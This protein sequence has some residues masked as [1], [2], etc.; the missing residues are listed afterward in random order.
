MR[1]GIFET[2]H[3]EV[4]H[5]LIRLFQSPSNQLT[6]FSYVSSWQQLQMMPGIDQHPINWVVKKENQSKAAFIFH[7]YQE[8]KKEKIQLLYLDTVTDNFIF[9]AWLVKALPGVRILLT[10]H[11]INSYFNFR[12]NGTVRRL[13]RN[14]GKKKLIR[15]VKEFTVINSAMQSYLQ[16]RL[17]SGK[18]VRY[19]PGSFFEEPATVLQEPLL[20]PFRIVVPGSVD[21]RR[22]DYS[23]VFQLLEYCHQLEIPVQLT[24][25]GGF[26]PEHGAAILQ[27]CREYAKLYD[28]LQWFEDE[29]VDAVRFDELMRQAH[30]VFAPCVIKT[31]ISDDI[32]ETYGVS[33]SS[34]NIG[35]II[36][37]ARPAI[38][39]S[40]LNTG[41]DI[42]HVVC[43]Y[44]AV[45]EI[46]EQLLLLRD[47]PDKYYV[48]QQQALQG[49]RT[50]TLEKIRAN[51][52]D[53][54][55]VNS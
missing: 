45:K 29:L 34:G 28:N 11:D 51:H 33:L 23:H 30:F 31:V 25:L 15:A 38:L 41:N 17:G 18:T 27:Q 43:S 7:I 35:D 26:H 1:I 13:V 47:D 16:G 52:P 36:R 42:S 48:Y 24:L 22:R 9:Y 39:P 46:A 50:F 3:F 2:D 44:T 10:I 49:S 32:E 40:T 5:T 19:I 6:V 8:V 54:F 21:L 12:N 55:K 4:A 37:F 14:A 20:L 53:L